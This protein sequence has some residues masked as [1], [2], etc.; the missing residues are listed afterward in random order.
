MLD[1]K[2]SIRTIVG[3]GLRPDVWNRFK[4]RF[5]I[6]TIVEF[7]SATEAP[8]AL[9]NVSRNDYGFGAVGRVGWLASALFSTSVRLVQLDPE[10]D[11]PVRDPKTG[12]CSRPAQNKPGEILFRL[13]EHNIE[14]RFQGYYKNKKAT[15]AKILRDV[16]RKGDVWF[17]S[18]DLVRWDS[19]GRIFFHDRIGDTF[20]WKSENVSTAEGRRGSRHIPDRVRGQRVWGPAAP[21]TTAGPDVLRSLWTAMP[22][23][24]SL[25]GLAEHVTAMLPS[26]A[27]PLFL[28]ITQ[29]LGAH[30][31]GTNKYLKHALREQGVA[32]EKVDGDRLFWLRNGTYVPFGSTEWDELNR[33]TVEAV[34]STTIGMVAL[35][36]FCL[37]FLE[38]A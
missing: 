2:H 6:D 5:G 29:G 7:Y 19:E 1:K 38:A 20:R 22:A 24:T 33:G 25:A 34:A 27:V 4:E 17:R 10:T 36:S 31:T 3:N 11:V 14:V 35:L 28:R 13:D 37:L 8:M 21:I 9:F 18:G 23:A 26:Y 32:P 15:D 16:F 12:L 30:T